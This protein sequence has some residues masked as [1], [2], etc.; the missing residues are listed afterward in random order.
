MR[1]QDAPAATLA[2]QVFAVTENWTG[3][4]PVKVG[5]FMVKAEV[6]VLVRVVISDLVRVIFTK[7]K[8]RLAGTIFTVPLVNVTVAMAD[9]VAS[10]TE[11]AAMATVA[12]EVGTAAG[13]V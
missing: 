10:V 5:V 9:F 6:P 13:A 2:P 12:E 8:F 7:P 11:V 1:V 4:V 3:F